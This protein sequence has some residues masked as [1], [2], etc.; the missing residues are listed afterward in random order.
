MLFRM[1][2]NT[3]VLSWVPS[4]NDQLVSEDMVPLISSTAQPPAVDG[5]SLQEN[6]AQLQTAS[7]SLLLFQ[8]AS[9][10]AQIE[11]NLPAVQETW[12]QS[13]DWEDLLEKE[14]AT[15]SSILAWRIPWWR[16]LTG[17]SPQD[18]KGSDMTEHVHTHAV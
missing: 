11:K 8:G 5:Q 14:M 12:A 15:H 13:L 18:H 1:R 9:L 2:E 16:S 3:L 17:S 6:N 7:S 10:A 4:E